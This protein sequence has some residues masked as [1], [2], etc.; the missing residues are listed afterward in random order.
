MVV[1]TDPLPIQSSLTF[2]DKPKQQPSGPAELLVLSRNHTADQVSI[3]RAVT[4][5][6]I[7]IN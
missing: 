2:A 3:S 6:R 1:M 4:D 5:V 7:F